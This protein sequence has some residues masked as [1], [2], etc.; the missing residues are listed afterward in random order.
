MRQGTSSVCECAKQGGGAQNGEI[1]TC[2]IED[3]DYQLV[4][5]GGKTINTGPMKDCTT[6][7]KCR[8]GTTG[9]LSNL[10]GDW[11][12]QTDP[13]GCVNIPVG[14][15]SWKVFSVTQ[16]ATYTEGTPCPPPP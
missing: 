4:E 14:G 3:Y 16:A 1:V 10:C 2:G 5:Q 9:Q 8:T 6:V 7:K 12:E 13:P 11:S 15:C